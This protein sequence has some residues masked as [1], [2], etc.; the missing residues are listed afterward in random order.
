MAKS[1]HDM[2]FDSETDDSVTFSCKACKRKIGY[3]KPND[4]GKV[5]VAKK[6]AKGNW[7]LPEE[8]IQGTIGL[9]CDV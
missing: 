2:A 8:A 1:T 6:D 5:P 3:Y 9:L 7:I 4:A